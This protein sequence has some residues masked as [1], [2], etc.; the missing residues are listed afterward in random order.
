MK[1]LKKIILL[2]VLLTGGMYLSFPYWSGWLLSINLP[3]NVRLHA[4]ETGYPGFSHHRIKHLKFLI[5]ETLF[6]VD[7]VEYDYQL[8]TIVIS[9]LNINVNDRSKSKKINHAPMGEIDKNFLILKK[10]N[11]IIIKKLSVVYDDKPTV[12]S[13]LELTRVN[14]TTFNLATNIDKILGYSN[15]SLKLTCQ[16]NIQNN[17]LGLLFDLDIR[18][19]AAT[20]I[21]ADKYATELSAFNVHLNTGIKLQQNKHQ[22][23]DL[24]FTNTQFNFVTP[25]IQIVNTN[26]KQQVFMSGYQQTGEISEVLLNLQKF[27]LSSFKLLSDIKTSTKVVLPQLDGDDINVTTKAEVRVNIVKSDQ[28]TS[29][30]SVLLTGLKLPGFE[31]ELP[32][33]IEINWS[34]LK[35]NKQH[36]KTQGNIL[37][38]DELLTPY[39]F[40]FD[41]K[42]STLSLDVQNQQL[43]LAMINQIIKLY[44]E[45]K[46]VTLNILSG[47]VVHSVHLN[48]SEKFSVNSEL[49]ITDANF[50]VYENIL[51]GVNFQQ[52]LSSM[53]PLKFESTFSAKQINLSS[54]LMVKNFSSKLSVN[55]QEKLEISAIY[56]ELL[57]G[58]LKSEKVIISGDEIEE[59][60]FTLKSISL[61]ELIFLMDISG[62]FAEGKL[63]MKVPIAMLNNAIT[64]NNASFK[65]KGKGLIKYSSG[66]KN[67]EE[68]NIALKA[69]ENFH[70]EQLDGTFSYNEAGEY[71]INLHLLGSNPELYDGYPVDFKLNINGTLSGIFRSLFLTG[72]F[73]QAVLETIKATETEN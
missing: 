33:N 48:S 68:D 71:F 42:S 24:L 37:I 66:E 32:Q 35:E 25:T 1:L 29:H 12:L 52:N 3:E 65:A 6:Y 70:Y 14:D 34:A 10:F 7:E 60:N 72:D 46:Q 58:I 13:N 17:G 69:L 23:T 62:L 28:L 57:E 16:L 54:G 40:N 18:T 41:L 47:N 45:S 20:K 49:K 4:F 11:N 22:Q 36:L 44:Y 50:Q 61:T 15:A 63:D 5:D 64:I 19:T 51:T 53:S 73:E 30:G 38:N 39:S 55:E 56:A 67:T 59:S 26:S 31:K 43:S 2:F 8:K 27:N 9:R 21:L